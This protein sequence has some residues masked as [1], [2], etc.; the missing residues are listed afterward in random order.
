MD[1]LRKKWKYHFLLAEKTSIIEKPE[2]YLN[3]TLKWIHEHIDTLGGK[4]QESKR[5][6][7]L[8]MMDL[9]LIRLN[10]DMDYIKAHISN[11]LGEPDDR[12]EIVLIH[13]YSEVVAFTKVINRLLGPDFKPADSKQDMMFVFSDPILFEKI[14]DVE[15][16]HSKRM[17]SDIMDMEGKWDTVLDGEFVDTYKIPQCADRFLLLIR[18][19]T[20]RAE[21]FRQL[22]CQFSLIELQC[23][24]FKKFFTFLKKSSEPTGFFSIND[25][26]DPA[27]VLC[28]L[29]YLKM[30]LEERSFIPHSVKNLDKSLVDKC[31][32]LTTDYRSEC[33]K[34]Q[35]A[36]DDSSP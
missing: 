20:E 35:R 27:R 34:I 1:T 7:I 6:F 5:K 4:D 23:H 13:T 8:S 26:T 15:W 19:I 3:Q 14:S 32:R 24:L 22:D 25:T 18:S 30:I 29:R 12:S 28:A 31:D 21:C 16:E 11:T 10:R 2:W 9:T 17:L 36:I 33:D